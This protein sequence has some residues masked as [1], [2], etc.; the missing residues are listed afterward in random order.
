[1]VAKRKQIADIKSQQ[2]LMIQEWK[3]KI[4]ERRQ[5]LQQLSDPRIASL[6]TQISTLDGDVARQQ[7]LLDETNKQIA[8]LDSRINAI[9][10]AE[11]GI[12]AIDREYQTKKA[13][14]DNLLMQQQKVVIGADAVKDQQGS[15]IQVIDPANL[16]ERPVAPKRFV[17]TAA[18]FGIGLAIGLLLAVALEFR[19]LFTIQT[20]ADAKHYTNLPVLATIPE[21]L[22]PTEALAIPRRRTLA[23]AGCV[24]IA[25]VS[26][27]ALAFILRV[28]HLFDKFLT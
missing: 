14:Y 12:E 25:I 23:M 11:V 27:P 21:L 7:K 3:D 8:E 2:D 4:E 5:K 17:L 20:T 9:P 24:A 26:V 6:K 16:P 13:N 15:G 18:G 10:S 1:V 28:T 19:R 22:T